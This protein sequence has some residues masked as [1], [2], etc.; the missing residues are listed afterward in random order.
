MA[1]N[2][3]VDYQFYRDTYHGRADET[4]FLRL[5]VHAAA[6]VDTLVCSRA[7][8]P[9]SSAVC[10]AQCAAVDALETEEKGGPIVSE[11]AGRYSVTRKSTEETLSARLYQAVYPFLAG[12]GLLYRGVGCR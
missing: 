1:A 6:F 7:T 5:V 10:Y 8:A 12:T 2:R 3:T 11:T 9:E 4:T